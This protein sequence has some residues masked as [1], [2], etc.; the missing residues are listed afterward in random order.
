MLSALVLVEFVFTKCGLAGVRGGSS[1]VWNVRFS[2]LSAGL[3]SMLI[4]QAVQ[5]DRENRKGLARRYLSQDPTHF[6]VL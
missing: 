4:G 1:C 2:F 5:V 3:D 6:F